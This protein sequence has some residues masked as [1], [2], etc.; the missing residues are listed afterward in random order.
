M[1]GMLFGGEP[2]P[3]DEIIFEVTGSVRLPTIRSGDYKLMGDMLFNIR[4]DPGE[5]T[6]IAANHPE[7]VE[8]AGR[9][10]RRGRPAAPAAGRQAAADGS[11]AALHLRTR[12]EQEPAGVAERGRRR[13]P[14]HATAGVGARRNPLAQAP[15]GAHAAKQ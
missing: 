9:P 6:D 7:I 15:K 4:E 8:E 1:T 3:R 2:S 13:G 10:P 14:R 5:T 12:R 11:A